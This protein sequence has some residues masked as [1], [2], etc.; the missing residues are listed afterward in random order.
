[1]TTRVDLSNPKPAVFLDRDGTLMEE[2]DYCSKPEDVHVY[3]NVSN[4]LY[5]LRKAGFLTIVIT[6]QAGIGRGYFTEAEYWQVHYE[7]LRQIDSRLIDA[8]YFCPDHPDCATSRRKPGI[9]MIEEAQ[10]DWN[11]DLGHAWLIGDKTSDIECGKAAGL[12]TILVSTGYGKSEDCKPDFR[13]K[14]FAW[15]VDQILVG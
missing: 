6:N 8:T 14:D 9:G 4:N 15:A 12:R 1:M 7:F 13:A 5:R 3:S 10:R 11:I 2:M